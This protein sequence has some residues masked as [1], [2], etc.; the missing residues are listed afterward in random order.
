MQLSV[1][2]TNLS[3]FDKTSIVNLVSVEKDIGVYEIRKKVPV[4]SGTVVRKHMTTLPTDSIAD[5]VLN[6]DVD[7]ADAGLKIIDSHKDVI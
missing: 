5:R 4:L 7:S 6:A 1:V 2:N 3:D